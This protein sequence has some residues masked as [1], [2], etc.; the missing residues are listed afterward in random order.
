[1]ENGP[2]C[3]T[4]ADDSC[5]TLPSQSKETHQPHWIIKRKNVLLYQKELRDQLSARLVAL[6]SFSY[7]NVK[8]LP[9][10]QHF[11]SFKKDLSEVQHKRTRTV[12][13]SRVYSTQGIYIGYGKQT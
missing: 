7:D 1:M 13:F 8:W 6:K 5:T 9:R 10:I 2:N 11:Q 4:E 12:A 3:T